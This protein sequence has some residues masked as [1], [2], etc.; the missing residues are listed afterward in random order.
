MILF[1]YNTILL[2][3]RGTKGAFNVTYF[4]HWVIADN[5]IVFISASHTDT[6]PR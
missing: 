1:P 3:I 5:A 4:Y 6:A 2:V